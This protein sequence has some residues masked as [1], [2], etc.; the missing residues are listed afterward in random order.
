MGDLSGAYIKVRRAESHIQELRSNAAEFLGSSPF[1][2]EKNEET[3][4]DLTFVLRINR[5]IPLVWSAIVGDIIHNLRSALD[6]L[7]W[8]L[9][10]QSGN[11]PGKNTFFPISPQKNGFGRQLRGSLSGSASEMRK[12]VRR[13]KPYSGGNEILCQ[14]HALDIYDKHRLALIVGAA[15]K[16]FVLSPKLEADWLPKDFQFPSIAIRPADRQFPLKDGDKVFGIKAQARNSPGL[17]EPQL[18]F[19]LAFGDVE[20]V[21]GLPLIET[22]ERMKKHVEKIIMVSDRWFFS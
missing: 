13:L 17:D 10:I 18:V 3:N 7:A 2:L 9:V 21:K 19:E 20:E 22:L 5:D 11:S 8:Q 15:H 6:L 12:F 4:G 14:L 16:H 1:L